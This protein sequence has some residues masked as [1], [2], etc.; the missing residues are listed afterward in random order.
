MI[1]NC[2]TRVKAMIMTSVTGELKHFY[3]EPDVTMCTEAKFLLESIDI[4][5]ELRVIFAK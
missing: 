3:L 5:V 2:R 1:V 4:Y